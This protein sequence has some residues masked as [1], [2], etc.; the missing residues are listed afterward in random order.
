LS[1][2]AKKKNAKDKQKGYFVFF[3]VRLG[4]SLSSNINP[5]S[6]GKHIDSESRSY[7]PFISNPTG[8]NWCKSDFFELTVWVMF[9]PL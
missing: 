7:K 9:F 3:N 4:V 6:G 5:N 8:K 2:K 1:R